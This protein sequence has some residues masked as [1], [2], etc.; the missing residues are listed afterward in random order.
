[1]KIQEIREGWKPVVGH[2]DRYQISSQGRIRSLPKIWPMVRKIR[3]TA[4]M[5][6]P[7]QILKPKT[8]RY[9]YQ[10]IGLHQD[11][12]KRVWKTIHSLVLAAFIGPR[13]TGYK[14]DHLDGNRSNNTLH[15]LHYVT[16]SENMRRSDVQHGG[17]PWLQGEKNPQ[18]KLS[19]DQVREIRRLA[20][21]GVV[22][23]RLAEKFGV[24]P[25]Q[26]SRI[27]RRKRWQWV[28]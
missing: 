5:T 10:V 24:G 15:N 4:Y 22:Q 3:G 7:G 9:G 14:I 8:D 19:A 17:R 26:I 12:G 23:L 21:E 6:I 1:M 2:E 18:G 27:V 13:Q 28:L 20:A 16:Q 25:M 11:G